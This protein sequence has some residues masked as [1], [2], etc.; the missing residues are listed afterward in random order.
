MATE[1]KET[2]EKEDGCTEAT[3]AQW[4]FTEHSGPS[5]VETPKRVPVES[6]LRLIFAV[7]EAPGA[8]FAALFRSKSFPGAIFKAPE[9]AGAQP[10]PWHYGAANMDLAG[11]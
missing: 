8:Y 4:K 10:L 7:K 5:C 2:L 1:A 3:C 11:S 9:E 6:F